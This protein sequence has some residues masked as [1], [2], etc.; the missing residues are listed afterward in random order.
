MLNLNQF[1][2]TLKLYKYARITF[3]K[4]PLAF[5]LDLLVVPSVASWSLATWLDV[6]PVHPFSASKLAIPTLTPDSL[7]PQ[8]LSPV[9]F[10]SEDKMFLETLSGIT[11]HKG[12][13]YVSR[14]L[15]IST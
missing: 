11:Q 3:V 7:N 8:L 10:C 9:A 14:I 5:S 15:Y 1:H 2:L 13:E 6:S 4:I 12:A